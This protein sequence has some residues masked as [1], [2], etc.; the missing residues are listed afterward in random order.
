[1]VS[2]CRHFVPLVNTFWVSSRMLLCMS[3]FAMIFCALVQSPCYSS[4]LFVDEWERSTRHRVTLVMLYLADVLF[5]VTGAL[6]VTEH[7]ARPRGILV[8]ADLWNC[9]TEHECYVCNVMYCRCV[10]RKNLKKKDDRNGSRLL[11]NFPRLS[12]KVFK[13]ACKRPE[14]GASRNPSKSELEVEWHSASEKKSIWSAGN[15]TFGTCNFWWWAPINARI[16]TRRKGWCTN[17]RVDFF[18]FLNLQQSCSTWLMF[19]K[20]DFFKTLYIR[21]INSISVTTCQNICTQIRMWCD[22]RTDRHFS[23]VGTFWD[24]PRRAGIRRLTG[25]EEKQSSAN[26]T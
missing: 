21:R 4:A 24:R 9:S 10:Y 3:Y 23:L 19:R 2:K 6:S 11:W 18:F 12:I 22:G 15:M 14:S 26:K 16:S 7:F 8:V 5:Q 13:S 20:F 25:R 17:L 1:M